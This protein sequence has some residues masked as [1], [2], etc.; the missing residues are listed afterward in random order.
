MTTL[1]ASTSN[2]EGMFLTILF[3]IGLGGNVVCYVTENF[4]ENLSKGVPSDKPS[5]FLSPSEVS[6]SR[7][8]SNQ[9]FH[10][11]VHTNVSVAFRFP[12]NQC[13]FMILEHL[14]T[15][16]FVDAYQLKNLEGF[17]ALAVL[18]LDEIDVEKPEHLSPNHTIVI[19]T[20]PIKTASRDHMTSHMTA[21]IDLPVHL[22]YHAP[23]ND[24]EVNHAEVYLPHPELFMYC[25]D[26]SLDACSNDTAFMR[27][28][29]TAANH[30]ICAWTPL[31]YTMDTY[32][33]L[34]FR[35][36]IGKEWQSQAVTIITLTTI[37]VG[38]IV[39]LVAMTTNKE[40][41]RMKKR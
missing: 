17:G 28:P 21:S 35:V 4:Q 25:T 40:T 15:G 10:R 41:Q 14:P 19:Y 27:A 32:E 3:L 26:C 22:R 11:T 34:V 33:E 18:F 38:M 31:D 1:R 20:P 36:P 37:I 5:C 30:T 12:C 8:S 6:V 9:G 7:R 2:F 16:M 39:L 29:C 24:P 23:S 13:R